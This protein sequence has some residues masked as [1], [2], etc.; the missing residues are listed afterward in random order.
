VS[1]AD[2]NLN[3]DPV[4]QLARRITDLEDTIST[5]LDD[6]RAAVRELS[7][8]LDQRLAEGS[9]VEVVAATLQHAVLLALSSF[10]QSVGTGGR[11]PD[12]PFDMPATSRDIAR[13][14]TRIDELRALL[15]G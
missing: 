4:D 5:Q 11:S 1:W 8:R 12:D 2:A 7:A 14:N 3:Q 13:V 15:L 10:E 9:N 6:L